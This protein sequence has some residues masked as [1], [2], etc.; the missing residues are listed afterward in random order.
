MIA[1][2]SSNYLVSLPLLL[3]SFLIPYIFIFPGVSLSIPNAIDNSFNLQNKIHFASLDA[4]N[5]KSQV[6]S[7]KQITLGR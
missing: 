1:W 4:K 7:Y 5:Q 2:Q 3:N 6:K